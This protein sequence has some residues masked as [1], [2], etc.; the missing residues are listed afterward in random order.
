MGQDSPRLN[1][2]GEASARFHTP[3]RGLLV[4]GIWAGL[5]VLLGTF[6]QLLFFNAFE[7]WFFFILVGISVFVIRKKK[8]AKGRFSMVGYPFVP[9][10]FTLVSIWLC[11]T[12]V[13]HA[14]QA[15]FFGAV[16]IVLGLPIYWWVGKRRA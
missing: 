2:L 16:L 5:L 11:W 6:E 3:Y 4:N 1:W 9:I 10:A 14:P 7:I 15:A 8:T 12:T 13:R